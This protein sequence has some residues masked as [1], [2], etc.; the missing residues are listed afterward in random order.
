MRTTKLIGALVI[1]WSV[2]CGDGDPPPTPEGD[3]GQRAC[4]A[5]GLT[6]GQLCTHDA[7]CDDGCFCNGVEQ[8]VEGVCAAG[9][10][11]ACDDGVA[12]TV[13]TCD[14]ATDA[15][16]ATAADIE[17]DDGDPCNGIEICDLVRDCV[18]GPDP[19]DDGDDCTVDSCTGEGE[20]EHEIAD[21][22]DDGFVDRLCGGTDCDDAPGAG[23]TRH[24]GAPEVCGNELDDD[25][26]GNPDALESCPATNDGCDDAR[27]I[28]ASTTLLGTTLGATLDVPS[29][30]V[31]GANEPGDVIY[32]VHLAA[33]SDLSVSAAS[34]TPDDPYA[35]A[36]AL[37]LRPWA[38]CGTPDAE[39]LAC[40]VADAPT[41]LTARRLAPGDYA[42]VVTSF[43]ARGPFELTVEIAP[44]EDGIEGDGCGTPRTITASGT[45]SLPLLDLRADVA[46]HCRFGDRGGRDAV[47][48]LVLDAP[49]DVTIEGANA[50]IAVTSVCDDDGR[51]GDVRGC[52]AG[53]LTMRA[54]P[55]GEHWIVVDDA[56][57]DP[58]AISLEIDVT[59]EPVADDA[60]EGDVC[61]RAV[62]LTEDVATT[63]DP[64]AFGYEL[65]AA[66]EDP[67]I[68][69]ADDL[70]VRFTLDEARDVIIGASSGWGPP[71]AV[72]ITDDCSTRGALA[73]RRT[74][75]LRV[76]SVPA[77]PHFAAIS[78][79]ENTGPVEVTFRTE[80]PATPPTNDRC[81][82]AD[83]LEPGAAAR[84]VL[85]AYRDDRRCG[86]ER[87]DADAFY[88]LTLG[89]RRRVLFFVT[90]EEGSGPITLGVLD[91]CD[92]AAPT[93]RTA[94]ASASGTIVFEETLDAG[95]HLV[96]L[97]GDPGAIPA[98]RL[99][100]QTTEPR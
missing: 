48:R 49:R 89:A 67:T 7:T 50:L 73:C 39:P 77:G 40:R 30:C 38:Q 80:T 36:V 88:R 82:D 93:C 1:A 64:L 83:P 62:E 35:T 18:P 13:D 4:V 74:G 33:E 100:V 59:I 46:D 65:G 72:A 75:L 70:F 58:S 53:A 66:C 61:A 47:Y 21:R 60:H 68:R 6:H 5:P 54:L 25:C 17:C 90:P 45:Y 92:D 63:I 97:E 14:P 78:C 99:R 9:E 22:D 34:V 23:A 91:R 37:A 8:C 94:E 98:A 3:A 41:V 11:A 71:C 86:N 16:T 2:A 51:D 27:A 55:A 42:L 19:C 96:M 44:P 32:R 79:M 26:N 28:D 57:T 85:T 95:E 29:P 52:G 12:C 43:A 87:P 84:V 20:C 31:V 10:R 69:P 15:C 24:P 56:R 76:P 81:A